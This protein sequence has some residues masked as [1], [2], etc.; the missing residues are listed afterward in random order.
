MKKKKILVFGI[1]FFCFFV[2]T[3]NAET[4]AEIRIDSVMWDPF[5]IEAGDDVTLYAK[6]VLRPIT[7]AWAVENPDNIATAQDPGVFYKAQLEP[8]DD[9][10]RDYVIMKRGEK[11]VGH[12]FV[13]E[14]WTTPFEIKIRETAIATSYKMRFSV[15]K[16]DIDSTYEEVVKVF[17][18]E[19]PIK[20]VVKFNVDS[21]NMVNLGSISDIVINVKN[22][23]LGDAKHVIVGLDLSTP[24]T[25][26]RTSELYVGDFEG[27]ESK[28]VAF[29]VSVGS[30]TEALVYRIPVTITYVDDNGTEKKVNKDIGVRIDATPDMKVGLESSDDL[31]AGIG[32]TVSIEVVNEGFIDAKFVRLTLEPTEDYSVESI[33]EFY[34]GNLDS[35]DIETDEFEIRIEDSVDKEI[36]PLKVRL[37]YKGEGS[38]QEY[39]NECEVDLKI[40]SKVEYA[41]KHGGDG[42]SATLMIIILAIP[43]FFIVILVVW[44]VYKIFDLIKDYLNRKLFSR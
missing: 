7:K 2:T 9:L 10:A 30:E 26:V 34:I 42:T 43:V 12:L 16:T 37:Q 28:D 1:L 33:N 27:G 18:F 3:V 24:F 31:A 38:D 32:G 15:I 4:R 20:G 14:S 41:A 25:S 8:A 35:D 23:G 11:N 39:V 21:D 40:L 29:K 5:Y 17:E 36:V 13:G 6:F 44:F 19:L 22:D